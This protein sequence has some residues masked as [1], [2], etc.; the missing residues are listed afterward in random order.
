MKSGRES[1]IL[2]AAYRFER[3]RCDW[4][5]IQERLAALSARGTQTGAILELGLE[6]HLD[7]GSVCVAEGVVD[8][9][10]DVGVVSSDGR[11]PCLGLG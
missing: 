4:L 10:H 9:A 2:A 3:S 8:V 1:L 7:G 5:K 6:G 11:V